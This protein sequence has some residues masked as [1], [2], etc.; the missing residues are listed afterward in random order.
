MAAMFLLVAT[1]SPD[2]TV[3][4]SLVVD[5]PSPSFR[6]FGAALLIV[7]GLM[8]TAAMRMLFSGSEDNANVVVN[9]VAVLF[10][11]DLVS[12]FSNAVYRLCF[13]SKWGHLKGDGCRRGASTGFFFLDPV[14]PPRI[15][16]LRRS[17]IECEGKGTAQTGLPHSL[18]TGDLV[19]KRAPL[20]MCTAPRR[21]KGCSSSSKPCPRNGACFG[22][23]N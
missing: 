20:L 23:L 6:V 9:S 8:V 5:G 22:R 17:R 11:A 1:A 4:Y 19:D 15:Y 13:I 12:D 10:I 2:L 18:G 3:G 14:R 7:F 21:M 16:L